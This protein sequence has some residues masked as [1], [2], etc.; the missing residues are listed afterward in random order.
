MPGKHDHREALR[1]RGWAGSAGGD[2][3]A[4]KGERNGGGGSEGS[5]EEAGGGD[6]G[7]RGGGGGSGQHT[8]L[9]RCGWTLSAL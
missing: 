9:Q 6:E 5:G 4:T 3:G 8:L 7:R 2:A 1:P